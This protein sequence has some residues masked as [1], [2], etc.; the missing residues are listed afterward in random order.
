MNKITKNYLII[1]F[2]YLFFSNVYS[3]N[4]PDDYWLNHGFS[5]DETVYVNS[6]Y[7]YDDG[8]DSLYNTG[9][10]WTVEFCSENGNPITL[11]FN[12]F[13]T[14]YEGSTDTDYVNWDYMSIIYP[15]TSLVA[16]DTDTPQF[17]FTSPGGCISIGFHSEPEGTSQPDSG[18]IAEISTD[19]PPPNNDQCSATEM[20]VG[21]VCSPSFYSNKGSWDTRELGNPSCH[22]QFFGGDVWFTA[23]VPD[24]GQLK[25]ETI[26]GSLKYGIMVLYRGTCE[27]LTEYECVDIPGTMPSRTFTGLTA[28]ERVYIRIFGDQ[29]KSGTFGICAT[30]PTAEISGYTGPGGVGDAI[31]NQL[32]IRADSGLR[33]INQ[34]PVSNNDNIANWLDRSG[35]ENHIKQ[36]NA[37]NQPIFRSSGLN[38]RPSVE[39]NG[40]NI[41][42]TD[43]LGIFAAPVNIFSVH[44]FAISRDHSVLALGNAT[45]TNTLSIGRENISNNYYSYTNGKN[46]GQA[47]PA[48]PQILFARYDV[49][50]PFHSYKLNG[51]SQTVNYTE[52]Q[53]STNGALYLGSNKD[54]NEFLEGNISEVIFY[55]KVLNQAQEIIVTSYL[56]AKY[57]ISIPYNYYGFRDTHPNDLAGIGRTDEAN[58]HTKAQSAGILSLGG[59]ANLGN[60][61]FVLFAH[62]GADPETWKSQETPSSDPEVMRIEREW[63]VD[64][65]G[66]G[67]G[68]LTIS[69]DTSALPPLPENYS[70][71]NILVD[72]DGDFSSGAVFYGLI[73]GGNELLANNISLEDS[74]YITIA[75]VKARVN[76]SSPASSGLESIERP[77]ISVELNYAVSDP[78]TIAYSVTSGTATRG[79]DFSLNDDV[80]VFDP[81]ERVKEIIPLIFEDTIVEIPNEFFTI[82][83]ENSGSVVLDGDTMDHVYT[84]VD[85]D[86]SLFITASD[87]SIGDCVSST[88]VLNA[89]AAGQ[90]PLSY[91]WS[92]VTGLS[93]PAS[94]I[95]EA[96]PAAT[97]LYT[98]TVTDSL[99]GSIE[100][101]IEIIVMPSPPQ[102]LISVTGTTEFC[103]GESVQLSAPDGYSYQWNNGQTTQTIN[104]DT[105]GSYTVTVIDEYGCE[106]PESEAVVVT[107]Y[108]VPEK[109]VI[110]VN[111]ETE[112]CEGESVEL[113]APDGYSY[114]WSNGQTIQ[115]FDA[116][117]SGSYTVTV[118][119]EYGC[120]SPESEAVVVTVF[121]VPEKPVIT[122]N[123]ETE[124]CEG[125]SVELIA[126]E[127]YSYEWNTGAETRSITVTGSGDYNVIVINSY[128]CS[129]EPS[130]NVSV[131]VSTPPPKPV[132]SYSGDTA[133]CEGESIELFAPGGYDYQWSNG[134]TT[135][136]ITVDQAGSY[137]VTL[138]NGTCTS[139][140]ADSVKI[141]LH[142]LPPKPEITPSG[143]INIISG[144]SL[145]LRSTEADQYLWSTSETSREIEVSTEGQYYVRVFNSAGCASELSDTVEVTVTQVLPAPEVSVV[146]ETSFCEGGS[147]TLTAEEAFS[148]H[149]SNGES[150]REI[151][152]SESGTYTLVIENE[153]GIESYASD[154]V[155]VE[156]FDLP[157]A[158]ADIS[159]VSCYNGS[160]GSISLTISKGELPYSVD[161]N[162]GAMTGANVEGLSA[163]SYS[164]EITDANG[165]QNTLNA[166]VNQPSEIVIEGE[167]SNARC[168]DAADGEI[169]LSVSGGTSPYSYNWGNG[170]SGPVISNL[171]AGSYSVTVTDGNNCEK[172]K[173]MVISN[174]EE[175]C[176]RIP[177]IITPNGDGKNDTWVISGLEIYPDVVVQIF[178]RWGK[179][180]FY[181]EGYDDNFDGT[182]NGRDL[183]MQSYH[184]VINLNDGSPV[185][186]GNITIVR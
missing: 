142:P 31:S 170:M 22:A 118:T 83:L 10:D 82:H 94:A 85:N 115:A 100:D 8:G 163:G 171:S 121:P 34:S 159:D 58:I 137:S 126:P 148:Y 48:D 89:N 178:D 78:V 155:T 40:S 106:S 55:S 116:D 139:P 84:I 41:Y 176:F 168:P 71:Y 151:T 70:A 74:S 2:P 122:V 131:T 117:T 46:Y 88:T 39:F 76:F 164:A 23:I 184:Y 87:T 81:G 90:P 7:F 93:D 33:D 173:S 18:W 183:P 174:N 125:E 19:P 72:K 36:Y 150:S 154:P 160:D 13:R 143:R 60:N 186:I 156:V 157:S 14:H 77:V 11:D 69:L 182:Y 134:E 56:A 152:V 54:L 124:I 44:D 133:L 67:P 98:V 63:K 180:V 104:A 146:G 129:S 107:V 66:D 108:P 105:S 3:Q 79:S 9:Q 50:S 37:S 47:L 102:P 32:W 43:S 123:G 149:W 42:M 101:S 27:S 95:T 145:I 80:L 15:G 5:N 135:P 141:S 165:C 128:G 73:P 112:I 140:P 110:T 158:D 57:D 109:P 6:G 21:N 25:V 120:E 16:Y 147:V 17:S 24:S 61:E 185:I 75:A 138:I 30:D 153:N 111:G 68:P 20:I 12:G 113:S 172:S 28:G 26:P 97:T 86:M 62:D 136:S 99:G 4:D 53:V 166:E 38:S 114:Q 175:L 130:G 91:S 35:N 162:G 96:N 52:G 92:P 167:I 51:N 127:G 65:T 144:E 119:D 59:A 181:S 179:R 64:I 169:I 45:E 29:A 132:I 161:W 103:E 49:V 177:D 1:L